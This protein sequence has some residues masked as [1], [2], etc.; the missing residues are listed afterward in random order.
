MDDLLGDPIPE[1]ETP[2]SKGG[3]LRAERLSPEQRAEIAR[4]AANSRW[5]LPKSAFGGPDR[6]LKIG[7]TE[8]PCYVLEDGRRAHES[9]HFGGLRSA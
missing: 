5:G 2:Q 3:K 7:N 6:P 9:P 1:V 8:L 4:D